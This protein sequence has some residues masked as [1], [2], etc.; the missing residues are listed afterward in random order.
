MTVSRHRRIMAHPQIS[1]KLLL[2]STA[3]AFQSPQTLII[4]P[5]LVSRQFCMLWLL[6]TSCYPLTAHRTLISEKE[7]T[8]YLEFIRSQGIKHHQIAIPPN[9]EAFDAIP[10]TAMTEALSVV[11]DARNYPMLVHCNKGKVFHSLEHA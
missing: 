9:K 8:E 4:L 5:N 1:V 11:C 3:V 6:Q 2:G 7:D 10:V